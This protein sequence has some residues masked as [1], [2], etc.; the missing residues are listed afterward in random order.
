MVILIFG[1]Y[2]L[3][4]KKPEPVLIVDSERFLYWQQDGEFADTTNYGVGNKE[5][6]NYNLLMEVLYFVD[7]IV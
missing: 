2:S 4:F 1:Y 6:N 7:F 3:T 5:K